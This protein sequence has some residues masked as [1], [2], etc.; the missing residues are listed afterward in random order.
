MEGAPAMARPKNKG[1]AV[2]RPTAHHAADTVGI[3]IPTGRIHAHGLHWQTV[4]EAGPSPMI[5]RLY[6][7]PPR[8]LADPGNTM[9]VEVDGA[10]RL[11]QVGVGTSLDV[12]AKR[13]RVK[14]GTGGKASSVEGW[15]VLVS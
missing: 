4:L 3:Q 9:L 7:A 8:A 10:K 1:R 14:A 11:L 5:Y 15:Y 13:I 12:R 2:V 6:N